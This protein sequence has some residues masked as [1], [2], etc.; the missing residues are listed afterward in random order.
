MLILSIIIILLLLLLLII[1]II[2]I[3]IIKAR[4]T[5]C[6]MAL[7]KLVEGSLLTYSGQANSS[8]TKLSVP[9]VKNG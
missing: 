7:K 1:I 5:L 2:I 3:I 6:C 9:E 4:L 8:N